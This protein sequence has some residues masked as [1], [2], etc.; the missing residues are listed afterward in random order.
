LAV[1]VD[2]G[3]SPRIQQSSEQ[4]P[5]ILGCY[6]TTNQLVE[7]FNGAESFSEN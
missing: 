7:L 5:N 6:K 2:P 4:E 3:S 1:H